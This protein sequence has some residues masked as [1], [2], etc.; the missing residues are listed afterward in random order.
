[1]EPVINSVNH[2]KA[3]IADLTE[4]SGSKQKV[5]VVV[6]NRI[7]S[8][9]QLN[10]SQ[11]EELLGQTPLIAITPAPELLYTANR[12]KTTAVATRPDSLTAQQF[13]KLAEEVVNL[14][15][16]MK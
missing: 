13:T 6:V 2:S 1:V 12:M 8:D 14:D 9:T 3:L 15:K 7:R 10:M 11:V 16:P 5:R 4:I